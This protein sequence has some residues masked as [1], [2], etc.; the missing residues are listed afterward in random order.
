MGISLIRW[1]GEQT[2]C[3]A[4]GLGNEGGNESRQVCRF[5]CTCTP[6][7][8]YR[9]DLSYLCLSFPSPVSSFQSPSYSFPFTFLPLEQKQGKK[10]E[11]LSEHFT[12]GNVLARQ[13]THQCLMS[14]AGPQ[15]FKSAPTASSLFLPPFTPPIS[16]PDPSQLTDSERIDTSTSSS[17][18]PGA[19]RQNRRHCHRR[20]LQVVGHYHLFL[21][22]LAV[23]RIANTEPRAGGIQAR[24]Q[25]LTQQIHHHRGST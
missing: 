15:L 16:S 23:A 10:T 18:S 24:T 17:N 7:V 20:F 9:H 12:A 22:A 5:E 3:L 11:M 4:L 25:E 2:R 13:A 8:A 21:S 6:V 1:E 19:N 14:I